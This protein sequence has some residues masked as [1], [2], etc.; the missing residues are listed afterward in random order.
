MKVAAQRNDARKDKFIFQI[1]R[2]LRLWIKQ[3]KYHIALFLFLIFGNRISR[4]IGKFDA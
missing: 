4:M 1:L 2:P 3:N